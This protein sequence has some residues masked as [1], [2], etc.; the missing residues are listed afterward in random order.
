M[1]L[2]SATIGNEPNFA[3]GSAG[4]GR[5]TV[6]MRSMSMPAGPAVPRRRNT[7]KWAWKEEINPDAAGRMQSRCRPR[8][9]K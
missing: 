5:R 6:R 9:G 2:G 7:I 1:K 3:T 4:L 8:P